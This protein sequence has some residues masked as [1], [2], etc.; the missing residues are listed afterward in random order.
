MLH[1]ASRGKSAQRLV[2]RLRRDLEAVGIQLEVV[3][4]TWTELGDHLDNQTAGAFLLAWIADLTDPDSFLRS[5]FESGG[6]GNYFGH[7]SDETERLLAQGAQEFNPVER[8]RIYRRLERHVLEEAPM[9]P[10]YHTMGIVAVRSDVKG[11]TPTPLGLAKVDLE[12][13]WFQT[14][15]PAS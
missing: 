13:V 8:A 9:V 11:L 2:S 14:E 15:K 1:N 3:P 4:V 12:K 6:S 10:L 7:R 5:L